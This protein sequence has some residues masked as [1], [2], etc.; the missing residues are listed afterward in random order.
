MTRFITNALSATFWGAVL[1]VILMFAG[2]AWAGALLGILVAV[3]VVLAV[4]SVIDLPPLKM[5]ET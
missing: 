2:H 1:A 5:K 4:L 3:W